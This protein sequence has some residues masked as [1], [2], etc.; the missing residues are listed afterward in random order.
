MQKGE[1][2]AMKIIAPVIAICL[3]FTCVLP[4][5]GFGDEMP[6]IKETAGQAE[7]LIGDAVI[8]MADC[9][10]LF[11]G[12]KKQRYDEICIA[13][14]YC[15]EKGSFMVLKEVFDKVFG[16]K[17]AMNDVFIPEEFCCKKDGLTYI[18]AEYAAENV[19]R[20]HLYKDREMYIFSDSEFKYKN[21]AAPELIFE[22]ID[23]IY[24]FMRFERNSADSIYSQIK[25]YLGGN[26]H[27]RLIT[28]PSELQEIKRNIQNDSLCAEAYANTIKKAEKIAADGSVRAPA[29]RESTSAALTQAEP[30]AHMPCSVFFRYLS[31]H[32]RFCGTFLSAC[33]LITLRS[34]PY[35]AD[36]SPFTAQS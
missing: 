32:I 35:S 25:S 27:P 26:V 5:S 19:L 30:N 23:T 33:F 6:S 24:R 15:S 1:E 17:A 34:F 9:N 11:F 14:P 12:G 28:N 18:S 3:L 7:K 22:E 21:S 2:N 29:A 13:A 16:S 10:A 8:F 31:R 36:A 20:M 4:S